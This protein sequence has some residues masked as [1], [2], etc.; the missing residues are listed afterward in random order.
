MKKKKK[1][2][3]TIKGRISEESVDGGVFVVLEA[4]FGK[5]MQ[6][7]MFIYGFVEN[8]TSYPNM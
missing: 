4:F 3:K 2:M 1:R 8:S 7:K 5:Q 6:F